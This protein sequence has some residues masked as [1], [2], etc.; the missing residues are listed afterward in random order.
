MADPNKPEPLPTAGEGPAIWDLVIADLENKGASRALVQ[1]ARDRDAMGTKKYG[2]QLHAWDGRNS[3]IDGL[4]E[5]LDAAVYLRKALQEGQTAP[6]L[7]DYR[8]TLSLVVSLYSQLAQAPA[9]GAGP[10]C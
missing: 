9:L 5:L 4:Q 1:V 3:L 6:L 7:K 2:T 10:Q 8:T